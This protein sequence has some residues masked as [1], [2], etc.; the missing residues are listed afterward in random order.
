MLSG[1]PIGGPQ[2]PDNRGGHVLVAGDFEAVF[3]PAEGMLGASLRHR[4][5]EFLRRIDDIDTAAAS[6]ATIGIP[7]LHPWANRLATSHFCAAGRTVDID[8]GSPLLHRDEN[9]LLIHGVPWSRLAWTVTEATQNRLAARLGWTDER[10]L[11]VFPFEHDVALTATLNPDGLVLE[12]TLTAHAA[13]AVPVSFGFHPY[14]GLPGLPRPQWRLELPAMQRL[15]LDKY[16]IPTGQAEPFD[17]FDSELGELQ[18]DD[19]FALPHEQA[20]FSLAG[21]GCHICVDLLAGYRY[22]Q[23]FAPRDKAYAALEPMTAPTNALT[24]GHGLP[25]VPPGGAFRAAFRIRIETE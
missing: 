8:L 7:L 19:G 17:G 16:G 25:L 18:F 22:A 15:T 1:S 12:T 4:G 3:L 6:G 13:G 11:A 10:L 2:G 14:F 5:V 9:G 20:S 21:A 23:I 24:S